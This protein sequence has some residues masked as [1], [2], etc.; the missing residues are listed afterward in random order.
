MKVNT[1]EIMGSVLMMLTMMS[2]SA[3]S[4]QRFGPVNNMGIPLNSTANDQVPLMSPNG[5]SFYFASNRAGG[6]GGQDIW[7]S[8]RPAVGAAWGKPQNLGATVNSSS[9]DA[10]TAFSLDGRTMFLQSDRMF[11]FGGRDIYVTSRANA[12]DDFSWSI[13]VNLGDTVNSTFDDLG[14]FY[15]QNPAAGSASLIFSSNRIGNPATDYHLYESTQNANGTFNT[16]MFMS[17]LSTPGEGTETRAAVRKDGLEIVF[18][19]I[20]AGGINPG[21]FDI[22]VSTRASTATAWNPPVLL[23]GINTADDESSPSFAP[24]AA[25]IYFHSNRTGGYGMNDLVT[26][27]RCSLFAA[28]AIERGNSQ[29]SLYP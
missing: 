5:L 8:R 25:I 23:Q 19:S 6:F 14:A 29:C 16:P 11:G 1:M 15:F 27:I 4:Q 13:P 9:L 2:P 28:P 21:F 7:V 10:A 18:G 20:R 3:F 22:W 24:D 26:A 12:D 17:D